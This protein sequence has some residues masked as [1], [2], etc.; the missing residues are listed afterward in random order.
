MPLYRYAFALAKAGDFKKSASMYQRLG[1]EFPNSPYASSA[2]LATGQTLM[3]DKRYDEARPYFEQIL[4]AKDESSAEAAHWLCQICILQGRP[5]D[6]IPIA[7]QALGWGANMAFG[8]ALQMD[9]ADAVIDTPQGRE[10]AVKIFQTVASKY[11]ETPFG[12]SRHL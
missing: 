1:K 6:A 8:V 2:A 5:T 11:P 10:E 4:A 9:L 12:D 7:K 3:R